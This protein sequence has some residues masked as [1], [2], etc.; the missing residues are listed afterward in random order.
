M[1]AWAIRQSIDRAF[2][3][4]TRFD[5]PI[6]AWRVHATASELYRKVG[7]SEEAAIERERARAHITTLVESFAPE[8]PL[9]IAMLSVGSVRRVCEDAFEMEW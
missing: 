8:E 5:V 9:R 1:H 2:T 3:A 7:R 6:S 4:L